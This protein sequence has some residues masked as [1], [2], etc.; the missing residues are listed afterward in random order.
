MGVFAPL[1]GVVSAMQAAEALKL[2]MGV[3]NS[4]AG[5]LLMLDGLNME[6]TSIGVGRND[7]C[8]VC[9]TGK[10]TTKNTT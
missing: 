2:L 9:G 6:W 1:V 10:M 3:G 4:L 5:R 7:V 8:P